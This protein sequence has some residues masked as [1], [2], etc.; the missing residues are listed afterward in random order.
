MNV[1]HFFSSC[2]QTNIKYYT[3]LPAQFKSDKCVVCMNLMFVY[4]YT[5]CNII[6]FCI[7]NN[8]VDEV[9]KKHTIAI[10]C[11]HNTKC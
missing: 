6:F 4:M 2:A 11:P 3:E 1:W 9:Q 8:M 10:I 5:I 7:L